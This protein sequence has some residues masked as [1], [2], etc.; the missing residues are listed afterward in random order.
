MSPEVFSPYQL[1]IH[2][3][4]HMT[5]DKFESVPQ[6]H[7]IQTYSG[8]KTSTSGNVGHY[9]RHSPSSVPIDKIFA[10]RISIRPAAV[11]ELL[12]IPLI[13]WIGD[14]QVRIVVV[15]Q[16]QVS[17]WLVPCQIGRLEANVDGHEFTSERGVKIEEEGGCNERR[18]N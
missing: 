1:Y 17:L 5:G 13:I 7:I 9:S 11:M 14:A 4:I 15:E 8:N 3:D 12:N 18:D 16:P 2:I 10:E 6:Y